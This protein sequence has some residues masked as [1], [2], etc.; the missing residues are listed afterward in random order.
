MPGEA[1]AAPHGPAGCSDARRFELELEFVQCLASPDYLNCER[2][3]S[4]LIISDCRA[5]ACGGVREL[6]ADSP[7]APVCGRRASAI[8][9]SEQSCACELPRLFAVLAEA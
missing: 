5:H 2:P 4:D 1:A 9:H 7:K 8:R 3:F 6:L